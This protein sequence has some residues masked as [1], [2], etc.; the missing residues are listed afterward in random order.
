MA[1]A[2]ESR[3]N[4]LTPGLHS[5]E[6]MTAE[7]NTHEDNRPTEMQSHWKLMGIFK[8]KSGNLCGGVAAGILQ[9]HR[10][11]AQLSWRHGILAGILH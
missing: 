4:I 10:D 2:A 7:T 11:V 3:R 1:V 6:Q 5:E 9:R 8:E